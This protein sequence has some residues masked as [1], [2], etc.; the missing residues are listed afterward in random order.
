MPSCD[1]TKE[2][3]VLIRRLKI[4]GC[5]S[6]KI[7]FKNYYGNEKEEQQMMTSKLFLSP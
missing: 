6:I 7:K 4:L 3:K 5:M 1:K 2:S